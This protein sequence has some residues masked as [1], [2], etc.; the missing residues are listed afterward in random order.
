MKRK[1]LVRGIVGVALCLTGILLELAMPRDARHTFRVDAGGCRLVTDIVE[2]EGGGTPQ[3]YVVLLHGLAANERTMLYLTDGLAEQHVRVFVPDLPGHG[4]TTEPFS[5]NRA[6]QC[7]ENLVQELISRGLL[8]PEKTVLVGHSMGGAI[9]LE[10]AAHE[11]VAGVVALSP[12][13]MRDIPGIPREAIPYHDFSKL[14]PHALVISGGWEP[15]ILTRAAQELVT[16]S[17]DANSQYEL[18]P[19]TSHVSMLF[20]RQVLRATQSW[21]ASVLHVQ[22]QNVVPSRAA[23]LGLF[24]GLMGILLLTGPFLRELLQAK[25]ASAAASGAVANVAG[26]PKGRVFLEFAAGALAAI[27]VL[28]FGDLLRF[29]RMFEADYFASV[30][31]ITGVVVL[32]LHLGKMRGWLTNG[33]EKTEGRRPTYV[34][35]L[36]AALA[37]AI[38]VM[39]LGAWFDLSFTETWPR[40]GRLARFV[41][42][43]I[44]VLP[45]HLAEE[46]LLGGP[47]AEKEFFRLTTALGLRVLVWVVLVAGIFL[48][49]SGEILPVLLAPYF[50]LFCL[51]QKWGMDVVR[52]VTRSASAAALFGAILLAGFCLVVFPTT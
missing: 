14:P 40:M 52:E 36:L 28:R 44:A 2:P 19:R 6:E 48:L 39:L 34:A 21:V 8:D 22:R 37:G 13:P 1:K 15:G 49:H 4:R 12:A 25:E 47:D 33:E 50:G 51:G 45:Y 42:L 35:I 17:G 9:A 18:V 7:S 16:G 32:L 20:S 3:G 26:V 23:L 43:L 29:L 41:P 11:P 31:L 30:L 24:A 46:F 5:F 38:L 10:L 27:V